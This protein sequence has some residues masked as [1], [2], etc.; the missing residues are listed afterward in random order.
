MMVFR[1]NSLKGERFEDAMSEERIKELTEDMVSKQIQQA[2]IKRDKGSQAKIVQLDSDILNIKREINWK[3][4]IL[5]EE[6]VVTLDIETDDTIVQR[7]KGGF[8]CQNTHG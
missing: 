6:Q 2:K 3:L 5:S 4:R 1:V 8:F 7:W